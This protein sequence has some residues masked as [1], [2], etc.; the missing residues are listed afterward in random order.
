MNRADVAAR[1]EAA[2]HWE[3][4]EASQRRV[5]RYYDGMQFLYSA[6]WSR[7]GVH[8]GFW[9]AGTRTRAAAIREMDRAVA[10]AL[11]CR[12]GGRVLDAGCGVGGTSRWLA[13]EHG[14][15]VVGITLSTDQLD[16][17]RHAAA[18]SPAA[19]RLRFERADFLATG[20]AGE[21]FDGVFGL[22]SVCYAEPTLAFASEAWRLLRPGGRLVVLDGF[23]TDTPMTPR[24][25]R[26]LRRFVHGWALAGMASVD[27]VGTALRDAGFEAIRY[28]D[29][30]DAV[31]PS[32]W[33][34]EGMA[35]VGFFSIGLACWLE[36]LP[37]LWL[38]H[39]LACLSQRRLFQRRVLTYG[40]FTAQKP[41]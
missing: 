16:R 37:R 21:S 35:W 24:D 41:W 17:A 28:A 27:E 1:A 9:E 14:L 32:A 3:T 7:T 29:K 33:I 25:R 13:E 2:G 40:V 18:A 12:P 11:D 30:R 5:A 23:R 10:R 6:L 22:E 15:D 31:M 34:M 19:D 4:P 36:I 20:F 26:D 8:Y 38:D 39:G